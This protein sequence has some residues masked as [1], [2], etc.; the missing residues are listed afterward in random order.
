MLEGAISTL[1]NTFL[2][3]YVDSLDSQQLGLHLLGGEIRLENVRLK[4]AALQLAGLHMPVELEFGFIGLLHVKWSWTELLSKPLLVEVRDVMIVLREKS[5]SAAQKEL[6]ET[7]SDEPLDA[8]KKHSALLSDKESKLASAEQ[9]RLQPEVQKETAPGFMAKLI[10]AVIDNIQVHVRNV[11]IRYEHRP[12]GQPDGPASTLGYGAAI[13]LVLAELTVAST[14]A[15]WETKFVEGAADTHKLIDIAALFI[16]CNTRE[17][18]A[19]ARVTT[20]DQLRAIFQHMRPPTADG[21]RSPS[22][23]LEQQLPPDPQCE[24][25]LHPLNAAVRAKIHYKDG[26][27]RAP[28]QPLLSAQVLVPHVE[29][30]ITQRQLHALLAIASNLAAVNKR[31]AVFSGAYHEAL[32][33]AGTV[34]ERE[35]YISLYKRT[36]SYSWEPTLS[37]S[38]GGEMSDIEKR[39]SFQDI[40]DWRVCAMAELT[41]EMPDKAAEGVALDKRQKRTTGILAGV[42]NAVTS[43]TSAVQDSA[44]KVTDTAKAVGSK[45]A[46]SLLPT[47]LTNKLGLAAAAAAAEDEEEAKEEEGKEQSDEE[48]HSAHPTVVLSDDARQTLRAEA[49]SQSQI[50]FL[51]TGGKSRDCVN[52][53]IDV[54]VSTTVVRLRDDAGRDQLSVSELPSPPADLFRLTVERLSVKLLQRID[55]MRAAVEVADLV[56]EDWVTKDTLYRKLVSVNRATHRA[57]AGGAAG[58]LKQDAPAQSSLAAARANPFVTLVFEQNP[59]DE[60]ADMKV[61]LRVLPLELIVHPAWLESLALFA[62]LPKGLDL[63]PLSD[64]GDA[65]A[66]ADLLKVTDSETEHTIST[67]KSMLLDIDLAGPSILVVA[68]PR[69]QHRTPVMVV[70]IKQIGVRSRVQD[71]K[72]LQLLQDLLNQYTAKVAAAEA[73][74]AGVGAPLSLEELVGREKDDQDQFYDTLLVSI[75]GIDAH[76]APSYTAQKN[77]WSSGLTSTPLLQPFSIRELAVDLCVAPNLTFLPATRVSGAL[78]V[79]RLEVSP[80]L[81]EQ[82]LSPAFLHP[83]QQMGK[84][85][86]AA[87]RA[88]KRM[89]LM[90]G[91][92][93]KTEM[94]LDDAEKDGGAQ[95]EKPKSLSEEPMSAAEQEL[96]RR[97]EL[98]QELHEAIKAAEANPP[99]S[100]LSTQKAQESAGFDFGVKNSLHPSEPVWSD[101]G[102]GRTITLKDL[103]IA[104]K[105]ERVARQVFAETGA[106]GFNKE[107][108]QALTRAHPSSSETAPLEDVESAKASERI[109]LRQFQQWYQRRKQLIKHNRTLLVGV[110]IAG[111]QIALVDDTIVLHSTASPEPAASSS[112]AAAP[113]QTQQQRRHAPIFEI[114]VLSLGVSMDQ[115]TFNNAIA[116]EIGG[117]ELRECAPDVAVEAQPAAPLL[118]TMPLKQLPQ[119]ISRVDGSAALP[120]LSVSLSLLSPESPDYRASPTNTRIRVLLGELELNVD[121]ESLDRIGMFALTKLAPLRLRNRMAA[122]AK[123]NAEETKAIEAEEEA[124][125]PVPKDTVPPV[126]ERKVAVVQRT[127]ESLPQGQESVT[128]LALDLQFSGLTVNLR[129]RARHFAAL[130]VNEL[131]VSLAQR[132]NAL[133][134]DAKVGQLWLLDAH[135]NLRDAERAIMWIAQA[136]PLQGAPEVPADQ[137]KPFVHA[138]FAQHDAARKEATGFAM[139]LSADVV[140]LRLR[141]A[142]LFVLHMLDLAELGSRLQ[143]LSVLEAEKAAAASDA[144]DDEKSKEEE[145]KGKEKQDDDETQPP[146][147]KSVS[148]LRHRR[149][150]DLK[151]KDVSWS[152]SATTPSPIQLRVLLDDVQ[153]ELPMQ[154]VE[155]TLTMRRSVGRAPTLAHGQS[156]SSRSAPDT[157][158]NIEAAKEVKRR[159]EEAQASPVSHSAKAGSCEGH[160]LVVRVEALRVSNELQDADKNALSSVSAHAT[161]RYEHFAASLGAIKILTTHAP[162]PGQAWFPLLSFH[163]LTL[164][165]NRLAHGQLLEVGGDLGALDVALPHN[166]FVF[167]MRL[168]DTMQD[169]AESF[170]KISKERSEDH[171][172]IAQKL[173]AQAIAPKEQLVRTA[174]GSI[175]AKKPEEAKKVLAEAPRDAPEEEEEDGLEDKDADP[176]DPLKGLPSI[177]AALRLTRIRIDL[178]QGDGFDPSLDSILRVLLQRL[179]VHASLD[180]TSGVVTTDLSLGALSITDTSSDTLRPEN[181][182][183]LQPYRNILN[184]G[185]AT[186]DDDAIEQHQMQKGEMPQRGADGKIAQLDAA[187]EQA[188][189]SAAAQG[190]AVSSSAPPL[191]LRVHR[192]GHHSTHALEV[193][194]ELNNLQLFLSPALLLLPKFLELPQDLKDKQKAR[195]ARA[196]TE[197]EEHIKKKA[198]TLAELQAKMQERQEASASVQAVPI[199]V[200]ATSDERAAIAPSTDPL[201]MADALLSGA[202]AAPKAISS[203]DSST[204][205][206][207][208]SAPIYARFRMNNPVVLLVADPYSADTRGL[209]LSWSIDAGASV[210]TTPGAVR[211][212]AALT[213]LSIIESAFIVQE[214]RELVFS[215]VPEPGQ[216]P[217]LAPFNI[218]AHVQTNLSPLFRDG[219]AQSLAIDVALSRLDLNVGFRLYQLAMAALDALQPAGERAEDKAAKEKKEAAERNSAV[220]QAELVTQLD[221]VRN[222]KVAD[223]GAV[224]QDPLG[225]VVAGMPVP[226]LNFTELHLTLRSTGIFVNVINDAW[227]TNLPFFRLQIENL[228]ARAHRFGDSGGATG[229]LELRGEIYNH[230]LLAWEPVL[231]PWTAEFSLNQC[232]MT[233]TPAAALLM[234]SAEQLQRNEHHIDLAAAPSPPAAG[235]AAPLAPITSVTFTSHTPLNL[236]VA[237]GTLEDLADTLNE[238]RKSMRAHT[239]AWKRTSTVPRYRIENHTDLPLEVFRADLSQ[240]DMMGGNAA[241]LTAVANV[242]MESMRILPYSDAQLDFSDAISTTVRAV[243]IQLQSSHPGLPSLSVPVAR[244]KS[245]THVLTPADGSGA[246]VVVVDVEWSAGVRVVSIHSSMAVANQTNVPLIVSADRFAE[247]ELAPGA[248]MWLP[249]IVAPQ[250][251][252][253]RVKP[254]SVESRRRH[255]QLTMRQESLD[256]AQ[257]KELVSGLAGEYGWSSEIVLAAPREN[258]KQKSTLVDHFVCQP[259]AV[260]VAAQASSVQGGAG[261][262]SSFGRHAPAARKFH[263]VCF[264]GGYDMN[265]EHET[266]TAGGADNLKRSRQDLSKEYHTSVFCI[267]TPV[268]LENVLAAECQVRL[269]NGSDLS[270]D[271]DTRGSLANASVVEEVTLTRGKTWPLYGAMTAKD[272]YLS[273][274]IPSLAAGWSEP[275]KLPLSSTESDVLM[276]RLHGDEGGV[277]NVCV[278]IKQMQGN[279]RCVLYTQYWFFDLTSLSLQVT[280]DK[281]QL[282]PQRRRTRRPSDIGSSVR[283][284]AAHLES[285]SLPDK[286]TA[287]MFSYDTTKSSKGRLCMRAG[288]LAGR[289]GFELAGPCAED[290]TNAAIQWSEWSDPVSVDAVSNQSAIR[291]PMGPGKSAGTYRIVADVQAGEG[292][293]RRTRMVKLLP[294]YVLVNLLHVPLQVRQYGQNEGAHLTLAP[295]QQILW[296]HP[297]AVIKDRPWL[298]VRRQLEG[299]AAAAL[300]GNTADWHWSGYFDLDSAGDTHVCVRHCRDASRLWYLHVDVRTRNGMSFIVLNERPSDDLARLREVMPYVIA[301]R[302]RNE[303]LRV[304]QAIERRR[305]DESSH[306]RF[307][308]KDASDDELGFQWHVLPPQ[309]ELPFCWEEPLLDTRRLEAQVALSDGEQD[310]RPRITSWTSAGS[311]TL[312]SMDLEDF[313]TEHAYVDYEHKQRSGGLLSLPASLAPLAV[314]RRL[315]SPNRQRLY[316]YSEQD[317]PTN[318]VVFSDQ[319]SD[320]WKRRQMRER[321]DAKERAEQSGVPLAASDNATKPSRSVDEE[322]KEHVVTDGEKIAQRMGGRHDAPLEDKIAV[323]TAAQQPINGGVS[324]S[325]AAIPSTQP[326]AELHREV[327]E[328][329][330][331]PLTFIGASGGLSVGANPR[332]LANR[333][334]QLRVQVLSAKNL[335]AK[336]KHLYAKVIFGNQ[337]RQ[338]TSSKKAPSAAADGAEEVHWEQ[339]LVFSAE[340]IAATLRQQPQSPAACS[341]FSSGSTP[342]TQHLFIDVYQHH[343]LLNPTRIGSVALNLANI[344]EAP[345]PRYY[346]LRKVKGRAAEGRGM[347]QLAVWFQLKDSVAAVGTDAAA[348]TQETLARAFP[349]DSSAPQVRLQ[350]IFG[351]KDAQPKKKPS[352]AAESAAI[353]E[354]RDDFAKEPR[355]QL[356]ITNTVAPDQFSRATYQY[357]HASI[358]ADA[359]PVPPEEQK[360]PPA[361]VSSSRRGSLSDDADAATHEHDEELD[362]LLTQLMADETVAGCSW[363]EYSLRMLATENLDRVGSALMVDLTGG[364]V[365]CYV[366]APLFRRGYAV[367]VADGNEGDMLKRWTNQD[368]VFA[369]PDQLVAAAAA[370]DAVLRFSFYF[371]ASATPGGVQTTASLRESHLAS[372]SASSGAAPDHTVE[373]ILLGSTVVPL[374]SIYTH[375]LESLDSQRESAP[376]LEESHEENEQVGVAGVDKAAKERA[377]AK[378]RLAR[379]TP[380]TKEQRQAKEWEAKWVPIGTPG[381]SSEAASMCVRILR[382]EVK[383]PLA[384]AVAAADKVP[385][386]SPARLRLCLQLPH[387][388]VSLIDRSPEEVAYFSLRN[389][390]LHV[391]DSA[392]STEVRFSLDQMQLDNLVQ[393]ALFPVILAAAPVKPKDWM[394]VVQLALVK[395][396][397]P[398][399]NIQCFQYVSFLLQTL[400]VRMSE[401]YIYQCLDFANSLAQRLEPDPSAMTDAASSDELVLRRMSDELKLPD[402]SLASLYFKFLHLQPLAINLSFQA[403]P[404][405]RNS[406]IDGF[407]V[408]PLLVAL[409]VLE[410]GVG[411]LDSAPIRLNGKIIEHR[412]GSPEGIVRILAVHYIKEGLKQLY[413]IFG[414][415]EVLGNPVNVGSELGRGV[416]SFFY[417][418]AQGLMVS[419]EAFGQGLA[420]GSLSLI[421]HS[422]SGVSSAVASVFSS[423]GKAVA[424]MSLDPDFIAKNSARNMAEPD[425]VGQGVSMGAS[426]L[427]TGI[428]EGVKGLFL[429]PVHGAQQHGAKGFVRG[430]GTGI[431]GAFAKPVSGALGFVSQTAKGI[432]NTGDYLSDGPAQ[433]VHHVR[434]K[435]FIDAADPRIKTY[436]ARAA[437]LAAEEEAAARAS[438]KH[439]EKL[440][441]GELARREH[442][443]QQRHEA[444]TQ[445]LANVDDKGPANRPMTQALRKDNAA[446][447][448]K[449]T[450]VRNL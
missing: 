130:A 341:C 123:A 181:R 228:G 219:V 277:L 365:V 85:L 339:E 273:L 412:L 4:S 91:A 442:D 241:A 110:S 238:L 173:H 255:Q 166:Q 352:V 145:E 393:D 326:S 220:V 209:V 96:K 346:E 129:S 131:S 300:G 218:H 158:P 416:K 335:R 385:A 68:D 104:L 188:F 350:H 347:I 155:K 432:S 386:Y 140:G 171:T 53:T 406:Y 50:L 426:S 237:A 133:E 2:S 233:H 353:K 387:L 436:D 306:A 391:S 187:M 283:N 128:Q 314:S 333:V 120:F 295:S 137:L 1:V 411:S 207:P 65:A 404:G 117:L 206:K 161:V 307:D 179:E 72:K 144:A 284:E 414:S 440:S 399:V 18:P 148:K 126:S 13:G 435:R 196:A 214:Q 62:A 293:F 422:V 388:G 384:Q 147:V 190:S 448:K 438:G 16:Y 46:T 400:D 78:P 392:T 102:D 290:P 40:D 431:V 163:G 292:L 248:R 226:A 114:S 20:P 139:S 28:E 319:P 160:S 327:G 417:E 271:K 167:L 366:T 39:V 280:P 447:A 449:H 428:K 197:A 36:L 401:L 267:R 95:P 342:D 441:A 184:F 183:L 232:Q 162:L 338:T 240:I 43:V 252:A 305:A 275:L 361:F 337:I 97:A 320:A 165:A 329:A 98:Q 364:R 299:D 308:V 289:T 34:E 153:I 322:E 38:E 100:A 152:W 408:N 279:L 194:C 134:V 119:S 278:E 80:H 19:T 74:A 15:N 413:K 373:P 357:A 189:A 11:H 311:S 156:S 245:S 256:A 336:D 51:P 321:A 291:M 249:L 286:H 444:S 349:N 12:A 115:R 424:A 358:Y 303:T 253:I 22:L 376:E 285:V 41:A 344:S 223:V 328:R 268:T 420:T 313:D 379:N 298:T 174:D 371:Y 294:A 351:A 330:P 370:Q 150:A 383:M 157:D 154:S 77:L 355:G 73:A 368:I 210:G 82:L 138:R 71:K 250:A 276:A 79:I 203:D 430:M 235:L 302:S 8:A 390:Q 67:H 374:R 118:R 27:N 389:L 180:Q 315:A 127:L 105:S 49:L 75:D 212:Q 405:V 142:P 64:G 121:P 258:V 23:L 178:L 242:P 323:Q 170:A 287:V 372:A 257:T 437:E 176:S 375:K 230:R 297:Q 3:K 198:E 21:Q 288:R 227:M 59:L 106:A 281:K 433:R 124:L 135:A 331:S 409:S 265:S 61:S 222:E 143:V 251:H 236:N 434:A 199:G 37:L 45:V 136:V 332:A 402:S 396:K 116:L 427:V 35:R 266:V 445:I 215:R 324:G 29:L 47:A 380:L 382:K 360:E 208:P 340:D 66:M 262:S 204:P 182:R 356:A 83:W 6:E 270:A 363:S 205:A 88:A 217:I 186:A 269:L 407:V 246:L 17:S 394:P 56:F 264:H 54:L 57:V 225:P 282:L 234:A 423:G 44:A 70:E 169:L 301:N 52:A 164:S 60:S 348:S 93:S 243:R 113:L 175:E 111:V 146:P 213:G 403:N 216:R 260:A 410:A 221:E 185:V 42:S 25:L 55:S 309:T 48:E 231:E 168:A 359:V 398:G 272:T 397:I 254:G 224:P 177:K 446:A 89:A 90:S 418:P 108:A 94:A 274:H 369:L 195:A 87:D 125:K 229:H 84:D 304:R 200:L 202:A 14:D 377:Q 33:R 10:N 439:G 149:R 81:L 325:A 450:D 354:Q 112:T 381:T 69:D 30:S 261:S 429:D 367:L 86:A 141:V 26:N 191:L 9:F 172:V 263:F 76:V 318:F 31:L 211:A 239:A 7:G 415:L 362:Q 193:D 109:S 103:I 419:P 443:R 101:K 334:A 192:L 32:D 345:V 378:R 312:Q 244:E 296:H 343:S 201:L 247:K 122:E 5:V 316:Y 259:E 63:V 99:A 132:I 159:A 421:K 425:H 107:A 92:T 395:Q 317:G 58:L 310:G 24:Y 151:K